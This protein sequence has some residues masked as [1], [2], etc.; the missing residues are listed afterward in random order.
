MSASAF[1]SVLNNVAVVND[2]SDLFMP[3]VIPPAPRLSVDRSRLFQDHHTHH[4][5]QLVDIKN[6]GD[7][8]VPAPLFLAL[9]NLS[10][11]ATLVNSARTTA[12]LAPLGSPYVSVRIGGDKGEDSRKDDRG[13]A[14]GAF[15]RPHETATAIL[16]FLAPSGG[17]IDYDTR[18]L[19]VT[20][21][22]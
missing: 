3:G 2:L 19:S 17:E 1:H 4:F 7:T 21:V 20:P 15:L 13:R 16:K 6:T 18:V 22:P 5:L 8:P 9:D 11:T 10:T 12:V 14:R